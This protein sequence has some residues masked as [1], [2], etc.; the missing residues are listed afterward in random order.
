VNLLFCTST[1]DSTVPWVVLSW[2]CA[3]AAA[4]CTFVLPVYH[5]ARN[6][7]SVL[8]SHGKISDLWACFMLV[9]F[10]SRSNTSWYIWIILILDQS[11]I[12]TLNG[13][14]CTICL[15][16]CPSVSGVC[17]LYILLNCDS[18][19]L[20]DVSGFLMRGGPAGL[21]LGWY[22]LTILK[23]RCLLV[24]TDSDRHAGSCRFGWQ[25]HRSWYS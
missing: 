14:H 9:L 5:V 20:R 1:W 4:N 12:E 2:I 15:L 13:L 23:R 18:R 16:S 8:L 19:N 3:I 24:D 17:G 6:L 10:V 25:W 21:L 7:S 11:Y 22:D